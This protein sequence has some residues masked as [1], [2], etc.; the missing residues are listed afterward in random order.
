[1]GTND[2]RGAAGF[3]ERVHIYERLSSQHA[4]PSNWFIDTLS[5]QFAGV[6]PADWWRPWRWL[7]AMGSAQPPED[8]GSAGFRPDLV[9]DDRPARHYIAFVMAGYHMPYLLGSI[10][11]YAWEILG[12]IRYGSFST[13][14]ILLAEIGLKHGGAVR[15]HGPEILTDL[16][17]QDLLDRNLNQVS[18]VSSCEEI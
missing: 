1:M 11:M 10:L 16:I 17:Q 12:R 9:D 8:V 6:D 18:N 4:K 5:R 14:D 13:K 7:R 3:V 15:R 2:A